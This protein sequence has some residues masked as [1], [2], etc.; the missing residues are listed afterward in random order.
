MKMKIMK[1]RITKVETKDSLVSQ[2]KKMMSLIKTN[3]M[4]RDK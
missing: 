2:M 4:T 3:I 1:M